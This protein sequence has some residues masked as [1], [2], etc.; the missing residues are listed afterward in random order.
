MDTTP[1]KITAPNM[2]RKPADPDAPFFTI[3]EA[4]YLLKCSVPTLRRRIADGAPCSRRGT[5]GRI[6]IS[7]EDLPHYYE[8]DR[9]AAAPRRRTRR[10][11]TAA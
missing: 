6:K 1:P 10:P 11:R 8:M 4:A 5:R 7:R 9:I 2:P 3:Q